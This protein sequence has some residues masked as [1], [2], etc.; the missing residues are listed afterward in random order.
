MFIDAAIAAVITAT[1]SRS[2]C[3]S[4]LTGSEI[5]DRQVAIFSRMLEAS[6]SLY[7]KDFTDQRQAQ[8]AGDQLIYLPPQLSND[9]LNNEKN[10]ENNLKDYLKGNYPPQYEEQ[11]KAYFKALMKMQSEQTELKN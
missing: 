9:L 4:T 2:S 1:S 3:A 8:S 5:T 11:I 10:I 7:R 6:R